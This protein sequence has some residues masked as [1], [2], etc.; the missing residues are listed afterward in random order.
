M[1]TN[2]L[3]WKIDMPGERDSQY[4]RHNLALFVGKMMAD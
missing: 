4:C 1:P 3:L 2:Q